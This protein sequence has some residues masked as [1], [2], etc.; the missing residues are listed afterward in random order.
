MRGMEERCRKKLKE[1]ASQN[2]KLK[3]RGVKLKI[4]NGPTWDRRKLCRINIQRNSYIVRLL[5][6]LLQGKYTPGIHRLYQKHMSSHGDLIHIKSMVEVSLLYPHEY[7]GTCQLK[8]S[9]FGTGG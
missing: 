1:G 8:M 9:S 7:S 5:F 3:G 6:Y 2:E 4:K